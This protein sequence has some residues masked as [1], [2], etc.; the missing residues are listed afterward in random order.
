MNKQ[1]ILLIA[2]VTVIF[3]VPVSAEIVTIADA[4][5][6]PQGYFTGSRIWEE[7]MNTTYLWNAQSFTG[8]HY[9]IDDGLSTETL[10]ITG[11]DRTIDEDAIVYETM[12]R[13]V[14]FDCSKWGQYGVIGFMAEK[15]FAGYNADTDNDITDDSISLVSNKMLSKVLIDEDRDYALPTGASVQLEEGYKL[16]IRQLDVNGGMTRLELFRN[17]YGVDSKIIDA[18][19]TYVYRKDLATVDDVPIIAIHVDNVFAGSNTDMVEIDGIFQISEDYVHVKVGDVHD[20]ME[21]TSASSSRITMKNHDN[22]TLGEGN[23]I[24]LMGN[25]MFLV[26]DSS[27]LRFALYEGVTEPGTYEI[28][29]TVYNTTE[30]PTWTPVNFEGF[31]YDIDEDLGTEK[32]EVK[33][34]GTSIDDGNLVYTTTVQSVRFDYSDWG[35]YDVLGFMAEKY[36]AGYNTNTDND[37]TSDST[38]LVSNGMLSKVLIDE[39]GS[40]RLSTGTPVQLEDGYKLTLVQLDFTGDRAQIELFRN[41]YSVDTGIIDNTPATY[42]YTRDIGSVDDVPVV[43][44]HISSVF[45]DGEIGVA[46]IDGIFQISDDYTSVN[47]SEKYGEMEITSTSSS[48]ITMKNNDT[49]NLHEGGKTLIMGDL[50][51]ETSDD[52]ERYY[53]FVRRVIAGENLIPATDSDFDGVPEVW[54]MDNSTMPGYWVNPQGTGRRWGDMNG[55][56]NL[57][58]VDALMILQA[59]AGR[60]GL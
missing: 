10:T 60:I 54:D 31:Y 6:Q 14:R 32:L 51:F 1:M 38:S 5:P 46:V 8:F 27:T 50:G 28:R 23:I 3:F 34:T 47:P 13:E 33:E 58:S 11:I 49:I 24:D 29:G 17:G 22:I 12:I 19:D 57:T 59:V 56:G 40:Y 2:L 15:Y 25:L 41:G 37:I 18:P 48:K 44:I 21:L 35:E 55:D 16:K 42:I 39:S 36:F 4:E 30:A 20:E 52:G 43:V 53:L 9:D 7:G 45:Y 26:A